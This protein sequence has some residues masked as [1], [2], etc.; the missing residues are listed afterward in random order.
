ML[1]ASGASHQLE[2]RWHTRFLARN[3]DV[4]TTRSKIINYSRVNGATVANINVFFDRLDVPEL[5]N[6]PT[7]RFYNTDKIGISQGV[8]SDY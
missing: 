1:N 7:E 6:I 5:A 4:K 8:R 2:Q 3:E